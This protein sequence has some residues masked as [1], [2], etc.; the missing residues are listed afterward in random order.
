MGSTENAR[1][2]SADSMLAARTCETSHPEDLHASEARDLSVP[3][4]RRQAPQS[5]LDAAGR[6]SGDFL[7]GLLRGGGFAC[8][9]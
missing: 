9:P 3:Q 8:R 4:G 6:L 5:P 1:C 7:S 2:F